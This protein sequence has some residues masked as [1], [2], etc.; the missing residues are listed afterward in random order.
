MENEGL[1]QDQKIA[2]A[3]KVIVL[4]TRSH[5][6]LKENDPKALEQAMIALGYVRSS[7]CICGTC[8]I[9]ADGQEVGKYGIVLDDR[10]FREAQS[11]EC[12]DPNCHETA[13]K[14][15]SHL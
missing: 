8:V 13:G 5:S 1:T 6:W 11:G 4:D 15:A 14:H 3:L 2:N 9:A 10:P 12:Q 7:G